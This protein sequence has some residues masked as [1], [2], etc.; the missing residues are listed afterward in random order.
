MAHPEQQEFVLAIRRRYPNFFREC[1]VLE[2]GSRFINATVRDYFT[3]CDY[4]GLDCLPGK[5]VDVISL[6]HEYKPDKPFDTIISCEA[7]EHDPHLAE[8]LMHA[9]EILKPGG[10]FIATMAGPMRKEH[11]TTRT[12]PHHT[13][14]FQTEHGP[15]SDFY[16]NVGAGQIRFWLE[17]YLFPLFAFEARGR[18]DTYCFGFRSWED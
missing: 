6:A 14:V 3:E 13:P 5:C 9:M 16:R 17:E 4:T 12:I 11:G 10:L 7:F 15:D 1:R 18:A 2:I 8:T